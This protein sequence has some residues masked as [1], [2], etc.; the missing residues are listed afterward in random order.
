MKPS[1]PYFGKFLTRPEADNL[2]A[3]LQT[4][5][6]GREKNKR[7]NSSVLRRVSYPGWSPIGSHRPAAGYK[8]LPLEAMPDEIKELS[9]KLTTFAGDQS[10]PVNYLSVI[11]YA[12]ENDHMNFHQHREDHKREDQTVFVV[13]LGEIRTITLR[14]LGCKDESK[15]EEVYPAHGSLYILP[16]IYNTTH[17]H[18]VLNSGPPCGLRI[19]I[20]CKHIPLQTPP[21]SGKKPAKK[22]PQDKDSFY[23]PVNGDGPYIYCQR[24]GYTYPADAVNVDRKTIFGNFSGTPEERF[25]YGSPEYA[26]YVADKMKST[27]FASQV[28]ELRGKNLLCWCE[29]HEADHCHARAWL[30]IANA[31]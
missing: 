30:E 25:P 11:G 21:P 9:A 15:Y 12:D 4:L 6:H 24:V 17:E 31:K 2:F 28:E 22:K 13:S 7:N 14:P 3:F 20:N 26:A 29:P 27:E 8:T 5:E 19:S 16:S 23:K 18:A 10:R 1:I